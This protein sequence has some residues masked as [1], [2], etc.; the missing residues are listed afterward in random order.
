MI[1]NLVTA[2][3][4]IL[5]R[6]LLWDKRWL[7]WIPWNEMA[8]VSTVMSNRRIMYDFMDAQ[9]KIMYHQLS[10]LMVM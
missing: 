5:S 6:S 8:F 9:I 2:L 4:N 10:N 1:T 7:C 3:Q